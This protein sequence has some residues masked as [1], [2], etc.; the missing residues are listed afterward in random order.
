[1]QPYPE[2]PLL[3]ICAIDKNSMSAWKY[4]YKAVYHSIS[5][6]RKKRGQISIHKDT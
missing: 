2:I 3:G 5:C 4:M 6:Y 1:M